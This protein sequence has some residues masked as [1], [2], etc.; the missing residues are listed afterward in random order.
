MAIQPLVSPS[1]T[2]SC[3]SSEA[4]LGEDSRSHSDV[5]VFGVPAVVQT[6]T[7]S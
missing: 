6:V 2:L 1:K 4:R 5:T 7:S 3:S